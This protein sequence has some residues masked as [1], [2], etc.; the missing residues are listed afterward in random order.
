MKEKVKV[1]DVATPKTFE[2]YCNAHMG[3]FMAFHTTIKGKMMAY[4]GKIKGL[5]NIFLSGQWLQPPGG[6]PTAVITGK[7]TIMRLCKKEKKTFA[8]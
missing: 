8:N 6:L 2:R 7:D 3:A 5:N 4:T 1:L